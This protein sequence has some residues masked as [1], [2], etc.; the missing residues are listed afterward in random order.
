MDTFFLATDG[1]TAQLFIRQ[2]NFTSF[3]SFHV[4][5]RLGFKSALKHTRTD[6]FLMEFRRKGMKVDL[7]TQKKGFEL[8]RKLVPSSATQGV[9]AY[10]FVY[11]RTSYNVQFQWQAI[12]RAEFRRFSHI[13]Y[14]VSKLIFFFFRFLYQ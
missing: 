4:N 5:P 11:S 13:A 3:A 1:H 10:A 9:R 2:D 6:F 7:R 12:Y 8:I 14:G